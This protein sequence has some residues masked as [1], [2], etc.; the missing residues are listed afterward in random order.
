MQ[1]QETTNGQPTPDPITETFTVEIGEVISTEEPPEPDY[2]THPTMPLGKPPKRYF[3]LN[4]WFLVTILLLL[5]LAG[6]HLPAFLALASKTFFPHTATVTIFPT[7][8]T[9]TATYQ[10]L[11]VTGTADQ[12][13]QQIPS[14][15]LMFVSPTQ[16]ARM[17]TTGV[18]YTPPTQATGT[19]SF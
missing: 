17:Q 14:R 8:K 10:F 2:S 12:N 18:G 4:Y 11:A 16:S 9:L 13:Q 3:R 7:R 15:I 6:E 1:E 19:I 5:F